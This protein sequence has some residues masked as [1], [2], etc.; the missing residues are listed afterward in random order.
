MQLTIKCDK[1]CI[2][3]KRN[4]IRLIKTDL[5]KSFYVDGSTLFVYIVLESVLSFNFTN[6]LS[7]IIYIIILS[8]FIVNCILSPFKLFLN[9]L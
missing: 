8:H 9:H 3:L 4:I 1:I 2:A 5:N 6:I 7:L